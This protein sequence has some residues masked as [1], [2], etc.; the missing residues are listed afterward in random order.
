MAEETLVN[1]MPSIPQ[2]FD[3]LFN[4]IALALIKVKDEKNRK[5][6]IVSETAFEL[7]SHDSAAPIKRLDESAIYPPAR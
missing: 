3:F 6:I 1:A 2:N 7:G 4:C 5:G